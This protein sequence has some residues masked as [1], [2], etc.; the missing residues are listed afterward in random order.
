MSGREERQNDRYFAR[1]PTSK[2]SRQQKP[3]RAA[4]AVPCVLAIGGLDPGGGAGIL[5]DGRAIARAGAFPCA[6]VSILTVQSTRGVRSATPV[7]TAELI[8]ECNEVLAAQRVRAIKI[9]ALGSEKNVQAIGELLAHHP[10]VPVVVDTVMLPTRGRARLLEGRAVSM[11][12]ERVLRR[13]SLVTANAPE[14]EVLTGR[15]IADLD[16][17]REAALALLALGPE[18]A[19]VKGGHLSGAEAVDVLALRAGERTRV[20]ELRAPRL[21]LSPVHG[22][23]CALASL[24]AGRIA[25]GRPL[26]AAVRWAKEVHHA[27]LRAAV[28]VGGELRVLLFPG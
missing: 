3:T 4:R 14:A 19:L 18:A 9:G 1:V 28:D 15:R 25:T 13:A 17:A 5:A 7:G 26:L 12:R 24:V 6:A 27:A 8:A 11:L 2:R 21:R 10:R 16:E 20:V 23:G 22:G